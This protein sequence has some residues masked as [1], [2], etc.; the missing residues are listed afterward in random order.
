M[1][2][3]NIG[4][5]E[6]TP[7]E[8]AEIILETTF[9]KTDTADGKICHSDEAVFAMLVPSILTEKQFKV[10]LKYMDQFYN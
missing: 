9:S 6:M 10:G 4:I 8:T 3:I 5:G 2:N 1:H 7:E